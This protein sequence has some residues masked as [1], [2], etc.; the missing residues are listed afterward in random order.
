MITTNDGRLAETLRQ[1]R[2]HGA[3]VSDSQRHLGPKPYLLADHPLAGYNQRMTDLQAALGNAQMKRADQIVSGR[4]RLASQLTGELGR[5]EW[6]QV[7]QAPA[8]YVHGYQSF[9]C[10]FEPAQVKSAV[11]LRSGKR[12]EEVG[13]DRNQWMDQL[14]QLGISTRPATHA[15]HMLTYY[16]DKYNLE[17]M[18]FPNAFAAHW[19]SISLPLF[20]GMSE[21]EIEYIVEIVSRR[22]A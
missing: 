22:G 1:L 4:R 19:C 18:D 14:H 17:P 3:T 9:P 13:V 21:T 12:V 8:E 10:L 20:H 2:D 15:V 6:L 11:L 7:P 5:L 16:R